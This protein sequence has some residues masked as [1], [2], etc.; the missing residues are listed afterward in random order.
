MEIP[1]SASAGFS[2][3]ALRLFQKAYGHGFYSAI[4]SMKKS[5]QDEISVFSSFLVE[6]KLLAKCPWLRS[7][8]A[9]GRD[10]KSSICVCGGEITNGK[11]Q[12]KKKEK[13]F[14]NISDFRF[15]S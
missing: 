9:N 1:L 2:K 13:E 10:F 5:V 3:Q 15:Q 6:I 7:A 14:G 12:G 8:L 11:K 4:P